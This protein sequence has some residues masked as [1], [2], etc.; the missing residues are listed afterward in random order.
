MRCK[1]AP[2][3]LPSSATSLFFFFFLLQDARLVSQ[4][5]EESQQHDEL[6]LPAL[7]AARQRNAARQV[8]GMWCLSSQP[9]NCPGGKQGR[10]KKTTKTTISPFSLKISLVLALKAFPASN[11]LPFNFKIP[12]IWVSLSLGKQLWA[13][14]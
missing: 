9:A 13:P 14:L 12:H 5:W 8:P 2:S 4:S 7:A 10:K 3:L 1:M 6:S 11:E